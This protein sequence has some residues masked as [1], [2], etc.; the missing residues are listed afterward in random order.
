MSKYNVQKMLVVA[1]LLAASQIQAVVP[2]QQQVEPAQKSK[3][4]TY[5]LVAA[6]ATVALAT[7]VF[8]VRKNSSGIPTTCKGAFELPGKMVEKYKGLLSDEANTNLKNELEAANAEAGVTKD[9]KGK[10]EKEKFE[11]YKK[12]VEAAIAKA[13]KAVVASLSNPGDLKA[14][15]LSKKVSKAVSVLKGVKAESKEAKEAKA[16]VVKALND[17]KKSLKGDVSDETKA[18][19]KTAAEDALNLLNAAAPEAPAKEA[20]KE[21][22]KAPAKKE[23]P[24]APAK[25][26]K[27][28]EAKTDPQSITFSELVED[29]SALKTGK[30]SWYNPAGYIGAVNKFADTTEA[31][32]A[33]C[34]S[35]VQK[36]L[37]EAMDI[38]NSLQGEARS[39]AE[40][41]IAGATPKVGTQAGVAKTAAQQALTE[42]KKLQP[43]A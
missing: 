38:K 6:G 9:S 26:P 43:K 5:A 4:L 31:Y 22:P 12:A 11:S 39:K 13:D 40:Q 18:A 33:T 27:A 24:K 29:R 1:S 35:D 7:G 17:V 32:I 41:L 19:L 37:A 34:T 36:V 10:I 42:V 28:P 2:V 23:D 21:D 15:D 25:D 30:S 3:S 8:L 16:I 14:E 20:K